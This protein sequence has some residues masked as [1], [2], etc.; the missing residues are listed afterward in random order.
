MEHGNVAAIREITE[1]LK[2]GTVLHEID[3]ELRKTQGRG[4]RAAV[5]FDIQRP[6][7]VGRGQCERQRATD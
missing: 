4:T 6:L 2:P 1:I 5:F 3:A 7:R